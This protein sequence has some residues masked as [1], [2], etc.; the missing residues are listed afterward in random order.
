MPRGRRVSPSLSVVGRRRVAICASIT[1][2]VDQCAAAAP[3]AVRGAGRSIWRSVMSP[4]PE[5]YTMRRSSSTRG[6]R[7][8]CEVST[9]AVK[10][11]E[12]SALRSEYWRV[13]E[14]EKEVTKSSWPTY[15]AC[16]GFRAWRMVERSRVFAG[17]E[18]ARASQTYA[19]PFLLTPPTRRP[20][21]DQEALQRG[22]GAS[23]V[24]AAVEAATS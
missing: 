4:R 6:T 18:P 8:P 12:R 9:A 1:G 11:V 5:A 3:P 22:A 16:T 15:A 7:G 19:M 24:I 21:G 17:P 10:A 23:S 13:R 2:R 20:S 14:R